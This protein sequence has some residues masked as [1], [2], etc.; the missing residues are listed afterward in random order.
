VQAL[1]VGAAFESH[2]RQPAWSPGFSRRETSGRGLRNP[3]GWSVAIQVVG[4]LAVAAYFVLASVMV[5]ATFFA[6]P[7]SPQDRAQGNSLM[8]AAGAT[9]GLT[10]VVACFGAFLASIVRRRGQDDVKPPFPYPVLLVLPWLFGFF[11]AGFA[12]RSFVENNSKPF[13][14]GW[15]WLALGGLVGPVLMM[16]LML[17]AGGRRPSADIGSS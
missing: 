10:V 17:W 5:Q 8:H 14:F 13:A 4:G 9:I 3:V 1:V 11:G 16:L 7:T 6:T 15:I 12:T 2:D